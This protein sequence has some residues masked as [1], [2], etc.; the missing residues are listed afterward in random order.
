MMPEA[1]FYL[2]CHGE[3]EFNAAG[4]YQGQR[5]S[6]LIARGRDVRKINNIGILSP[7]SAYCCQL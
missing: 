2:P 1:A 6:P 3:S 7:N 5:H 4:R